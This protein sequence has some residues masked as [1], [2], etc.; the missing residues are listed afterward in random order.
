MTVAGTP[1]RSGGHNAIS[2]AEHLRKGT[3]RPAR[4]AGRTD[5]PELPVT[6]AER[7]RVL[8]GLTPEGRRIAAALL[9]A[10]GDWD[11]SGLATL[12]SYAASCARL[13]VLEDAPGDGR[14]LYAEIRANI[15]LARL[16]NL[17]GA[18]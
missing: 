13:R 14:Q 5:P 12:R 16:L 11:A 10:Y 8:D 17:E 2:I 6:P 15:G 4:H 3:Y 1:G 18:R 9:D 7:R